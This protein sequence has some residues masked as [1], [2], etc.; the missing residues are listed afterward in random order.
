MCRLK[1]KK[2]F[3]LNLIIL[4]IKIPSVFHVC[5]WCI[6]QFNFFFKI[7]CK[8]FIFNSVCF[9]CALNLIKKK[10]N[11]SL[12][13]QLHCSS[14]KDEHN[15]QADLVSMYFQVESFNSLTLGLVISKDARLQLVQIVE[16]KGTKTMQNVVLY[17]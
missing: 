2:I 6:R 8:F 3:F 7:F 11:F 12:K 4:K 17:K 1:L 5:F 15:K 10:K 13:T 9:M 14:Q 16:K